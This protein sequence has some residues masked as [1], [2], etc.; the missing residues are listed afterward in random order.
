MLPATFLSSALVPLFSHAFENVAHLEE[1]PEVSLRLLVEGTGLH[2]R[3]QDAAIP[4]IS[5]AVLA[6]PPYVHDGDEPLPGLEHVSYLA[7]LLA[8]LGPCVQPDSGHRVRLDDRHYQAD[9]LLLDGGGGQHLLCQLVGSLH[10]VGLLPLRQGSQV[11]EIGRPGLLRLLN[12]V[13][14]SCKFTLCTDS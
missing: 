7:E 5:P 2:T 12:R 10:W 8:F 14:I 3:P 1:E 11:G 9:T 6:R 13:S 4:V